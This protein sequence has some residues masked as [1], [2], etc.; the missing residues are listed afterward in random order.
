MFA[1]E[2]KKEKLLF[3]R[4]NDK[5]FVQHAF[6]PFGQKDEMKPFLSKDFFSFLQNSQ[7]LEKRSF[8]KKEKKGQRLFGGR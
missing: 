1:L 4:F 8:R 6:V 2:C 3:L 7:N 5:L